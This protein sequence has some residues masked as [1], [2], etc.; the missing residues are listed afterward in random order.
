MGQIA[1]MVLECG[2][3][4]DCPSPHLERG[5]AVGDPLL[6]LR[7]DIQDRLPEP[8]QR[9]ALRFFQRIQVLVDLL[10]GHG[11]ILATALPHHKRARPWDIRF[12]A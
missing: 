2:E 5:D 12:C 7:D 8:G 4:G 11:P 10:G 9:G 6:G 1:E 3:P